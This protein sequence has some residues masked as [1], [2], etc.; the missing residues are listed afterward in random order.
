MGRWLLFIWWRIISNTMWYIINDDDGGGDT[1]F[2]TDWTLPINGTLD[3]NEIKYDGKFTYNHNG[4]QLGD[5]IE[6]KIGDV[7]VMFLGRLL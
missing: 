3:N 1:I 5:T 4:S 2:V 7:L 6:Y